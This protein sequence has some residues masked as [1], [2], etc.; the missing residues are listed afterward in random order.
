MNFEMKPI[1]VT[2]VLDKF[3]LLHNPPP[4]LPGRVFGDWPHHRIVFASNV[5]AEIFA[6]LDSE[7]AES[8]YNYGM[9]LDLMFYPDRPCL[10]CEEQPADTTLYPLSELCTWCA[11]ALN[12]ESRPE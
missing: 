11:R 8:Y 7:L 9:M 3:E 4:R 1:E 12:W 5:D 6:A 10:A 2:V